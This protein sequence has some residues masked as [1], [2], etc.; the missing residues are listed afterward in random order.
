M[1]ENILIFRTDLALEASEKL[2]QNIDGIEQKIEEFKCLK[3]TEIIIK[4]EDAAKKIGKPKGKYI[5]FCPMMSEKN[6]N[7]I[8]TIM[9]EAKSWFLEMGLAED[10]IIFYKSTSEMGTLG[11]KNREA[12]YNDT[13]LDNRD[14]SNKL[15]V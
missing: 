15:R 9:K 1:E 6:V 8:D 2:T 4:T 3:S 11:K 7:D 14:T 12:F 13:D 5:Y 10:E